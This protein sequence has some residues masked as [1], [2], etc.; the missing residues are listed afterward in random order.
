MLHLREYR[1]FAEQ[2]SQGETQSCHGWN[3]AR[4]RAGC[5]DDMTFEQ[6]CDSCPSTSHSPCNGSMV[7]LLS[8]TK[9]SAATRGNRVFI[10]LTV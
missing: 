9:E 8:R 3:R 2:C 1:E 6:L 4:R 10:A 7:L 5:G